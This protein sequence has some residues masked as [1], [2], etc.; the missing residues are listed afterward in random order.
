M[1]CLRCAIDNN[2]DVTNVRLLSSK[3]TTGYLG[4]C[5]A[6]FSAEK[7][8]FL[9]D[10]AL[11]HGKHLLCDLL[12]RT[13]N[14]NIISRFAQAKNIFSFMCLCRSVYWR[15]ANEN[16]I[17]SLLSHVWDRRQHMHCSGCTS[18]DRQLPVA[19]SFLSHR[20][21]MPSRIFCSQ[22]SQSCSFFASHCPAR[23]SCRERRHRR[24]SGRAEGDFSDRF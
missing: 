5:D 21:D 4:T 2:F 13:R 9:T 24:F 14:D 15:S 11:C 19:R 22:Y 3:G 8:I 16:A 18:L 23:H 10:F 17:T 7:S 12:T 6:D 1:H 20:K